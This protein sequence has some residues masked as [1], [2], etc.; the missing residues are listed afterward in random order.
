MKT[1]G[2]EPYVIPLCTN[3][4]KANIILVQC[5]IITERN[6]GSQCELEYYHG[7]DFENSC[8]S[9][10]RSMTE[11]QTLFL[12]LSSL[13]PEDEVIVTCECSRSDGTFHLR[14]NVTVEGE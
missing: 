13:T 11:N 7:E 1:T 12:H 5:T 10:F 4:T 14:L 6:R 9:R 2:K 8:D 3:T